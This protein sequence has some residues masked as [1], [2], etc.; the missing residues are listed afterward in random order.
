M[1]HI[2]TPL[3]RYDLLQKVYASIPVNDDITWHISRSSRREGLIGCEF[4]NTDKRIRYYELDCLDTNTTA[5]RNTCFSEI[6]SGYFCLLDDD[7]QFHPGMYETYQ[8]CLSSNFEGMMIG[9]QLWPDG[10]IRLE[11]NRPQ[12]GKVDAGNVLSHSSCLT[13]CKWPEKSEKSCCW[14][15]FFWKDVYDFY[16]DYKTTDSIISVYNSIKF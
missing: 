14:D 15:Y 2:V 9:K 10:R 12:I 16:K 11:A 5:K 4:I 13:E 7:T 6:K 3:Y 1:L 8:K